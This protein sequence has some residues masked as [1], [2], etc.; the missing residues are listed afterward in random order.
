MKGVKIVLFSVIISSLACALA[1]AG[2]DVERG[3]KLFND[4][5]I[6]GATSGKSCDTCHPGGSGLEQAGMKKEFHL[7]GGKQGNLE[8]AI[9]LC[10]LKALNGNALDPQSQEM[11]DLTAYIKSLS[12]E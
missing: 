1:F 8:E 7:G 4:P 12:T 11:Q 6:S 3:K 2:G 5:K 9:N 10:I